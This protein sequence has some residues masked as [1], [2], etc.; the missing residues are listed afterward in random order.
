MQPIEPTTAQID[1]VRKLI[2]SVTP[3]NSYAEYEKARLQAA[4][5]F[6]EYGADRQDD[7]RVAGGR[8]FTLVQ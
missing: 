2:R 3:E 6:V 8:V 5:R 7:R 4:L 1:L